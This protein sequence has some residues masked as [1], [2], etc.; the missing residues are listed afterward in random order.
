[1]SAPATNPK[2]RT[3]AEIIRELVMEQQK[4]ETPMKQVLKIA[5]PTPTVG[6]VHAECVEFD[7]ENRLTEDALRQLW[8]HFPQ[9]IE[10]HHVLL[11]VLVLNKLY[12]TRIR[13]IEVERM[14]GH[15]ADLHLDPLLAHGSPGAVDLI[16]NC[17]KLRKH[18]SFATKFCSWHNPTVYPIYDSR[19]DECLWSY[20]KQAQFA[21]FYRKDFKSY[22]KFLAVVTAFRNFYGHES[23]T[24]RQLDKF[25]WRMGEDQRD[26]GF[27]ESSVVQP[28]RQR[29]AEILPRV[30]R[31]FL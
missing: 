23:L 25:L 9:N 4:L 27:F 18:F 29:F 28:P 16:T 21:N 12:S 30:S 10:P 24:F 6:L 14:A 15:I 8:E 7:H 20:K 1:M 3:A 26:L 17:G 19:V 2:M 5:L 22:E 11:K 31:A 13:D